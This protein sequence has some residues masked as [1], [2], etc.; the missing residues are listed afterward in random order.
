ME[1]KTHLLTELQT[2]ITGV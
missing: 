2:K 1:L